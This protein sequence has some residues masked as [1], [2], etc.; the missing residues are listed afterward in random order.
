LKSI[1]EKI[2]DATKNAGDTEVIDALFLKARYQAKIGDFTT[3]EQTYDEIL[4]KPK[5]VT[6]RK[7]DA[8]MEKARIAFFTLVRVTRFSLPGFQPLTGINLSP[9]RITIN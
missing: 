9:I 8:N 4:S 2:E 1:D 7:I 3:A 6:G 5:T